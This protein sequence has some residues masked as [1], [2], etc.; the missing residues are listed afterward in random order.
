MCGGGMRAGSSVR[1][2]EACPE[3]LDR[4]IHGEFAKQT[5]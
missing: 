2:A 4:G 5:R 1:L 3:K